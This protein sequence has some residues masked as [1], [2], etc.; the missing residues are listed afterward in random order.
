MIRWYLDFTCYCGTDYSFDV[1]EIEVPTKV[2][3][4]FVGEREYFYY[5]HTSGK[6]KVVIYT[7]GEIRS[8]E[9]PDEKK[10]GWW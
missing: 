8:V 1:T 9:V 6:N 5:C 2:A 3:P 7:Y 10:T 4:G